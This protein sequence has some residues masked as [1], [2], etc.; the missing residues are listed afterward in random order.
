M[1]FFVF[2]MISKL[3]VILKKMAGLTFALINFN[4]ISL[5]TEEIG[6]MRNHIDRFWVPAKIN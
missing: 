6:N 2:H 3:L 4:C 5:F 1:Q